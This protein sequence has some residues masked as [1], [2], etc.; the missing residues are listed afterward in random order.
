[1]DYQKILD[2][3]FALN[4]DIRYAGLIDEAGTLISWRHASRD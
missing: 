3:I 2:A 1:M 4:S